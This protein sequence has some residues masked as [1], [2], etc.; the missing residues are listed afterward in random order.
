MRESSIAATGAYVIGKKTVT[1]AAA[2]YTPSAA[3][4]MKEK[5]KFNDN[6]AMC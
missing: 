1:V 3:K 5:S 2:G 6:Y 4:P